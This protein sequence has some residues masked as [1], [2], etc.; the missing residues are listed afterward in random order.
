MSKMLAL[1]AQARSIEY[2]VSAVEASAS[3]AS[4]WIILGD[5]TTDGRGSTDDANNRYDSR[6]AFLFFFWVEETY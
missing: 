2:F 3:N 5:S 1:R 4:A 6:R